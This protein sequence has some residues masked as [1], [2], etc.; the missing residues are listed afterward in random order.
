MDS[1][2]QPLP[3]LH[4][5]HMP[6]LL[7][8]GGMHR[9]LSRVEDIH[10]IELSLSELQTTLPLSNDGSDEDI[11]TCL[12]VDIGIR[13]FA[14]LNQASQA[15]FWDL[16]QNPSYLSPTSFIVAFRRVLLQKES[17]LSPS[18]IHF[19]ESLFLKRWEK[20]LLP[21]LCKSLSSADEEACNLIIRDL[22]SLPD[23][24]ATCA[25][26]ASLSLRQLHALWI[27]SNFTTDIISKMCQWEMS[28]SSHSAKW[29]QLSYPLR[30]SILAS[31][32]AQDLLPLLEGMSS[33]KPCLRAFGSYILR[34]I[35]TQTETSRRRLRKVLVGW[36]ALHASNRHGSLSLSSSS[37]SNSNANANSSSGYLC[38]SSLLGVHLSDMQACSLISA[39]LTMQTPSFWAA[40]GSLATWLLS[41]MSDPIVGLEHVS[42][43]AVLHLTS[44]STSYHN[45]TMLLW[46]WFAVGFCRALAPPT[47][48]NTLP[49]LLHPQLME[50]VSACLSSA[51]PAA[52]RV[53]KR[54]L[55]IFATLLPV[56]GSN[57]LEQGNENDRDEM[58]EALLLDG[59]TSQWEDWEQYLTPANGSSSTAAPQKD[60][61]VEEVEQFLPKTASLSGG[62]L[63]AEDGMVVASGSDE[64]VP[65]WDDPDASYHGSDSES[66]EHASQSETATESDDFTPYDLPDVKEEEDNHLAPHGKQK[67]SESAGRNQLSFFSDVVAAFKAS[68]KDSGYEHWR[69]KCAAMQSLPTILARGGIDVHPVQVPSLMT[70]LLAATNEASID[71]WEEARTQALLALLRTFPAP[72]S[73][74]CVESFFSASFSISQRLDALQHL[75]QS[76]EAWANPSRQSESQP[77][78]SKMSTMSKATTTTPAASQSHPSPRSVSST[79][80]VSEKEKVEEEEEASPLVG[81]GKTRRWGWTVPGRQP[82]SN[83]VNLWAQIHVPIMNTLMAGVVHPPHPIPLRA[84]GGLL[85]GSVLRTLGHGMMAAGFSLHHQHLPELL[86]DFGEQYVRD[87]LPVCRESAVFLVA[88]TLAVLPQSVPVLPAPV[89]QRWKLILEECMHHDSSTNVGKLAAASYTSLRKLSVL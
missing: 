63:E 13:W 86:L 34:E 79:D 14:L 89:V 42:S 18:D 32:A 73:T 80:R 69:S 72:A 41:C 17:S 22:M 71:E 20:N 25:S 43:I 16:I 15:I 46:L 8:G 82:S 24:M 53:G 67:Q 33:A 52:V 61:K 4:T 35:E 2:L 19:L 47:T 30:R 48:S 74:A 51:Q 23:V 6:S 66:V 62:T 28:T 37:P 75:Q 21:L 77:S 64:T 26:A 81:V 9:R 60:E 65:W 68:T 11:M 70:L 1:W 12:L 45:G 76:M 39:T 88:C 38:F 55:S 3:S 5:P 50:A 44:P 54:C 40:L 84:E 10:V 58:E 27:P 87:D 31:C 78:Q 49:A 57:P 59:N 29:D 56:G 7:A 36:L 83:F 85:L